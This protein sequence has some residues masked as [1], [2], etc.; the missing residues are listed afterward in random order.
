MPAVMPEAAAASELSTS[1]AST[2][3]RMKSLTGR[4]PN[5]S[6]PNFFRK[7]SFN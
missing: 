4:L 7:M 1:T 5:R 3:V 6:R 2:S